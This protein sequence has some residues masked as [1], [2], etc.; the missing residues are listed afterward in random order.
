M[1]FEGPLFLFEQISK[2][3]PISRENL[4]KI[5]RE[6]FPQ[7]QIEITDLAGD[8]DHYS[9]K[10]VDKIFDKKSRVQQHQMVNKALSG[11]LGTTLHALQINTSAN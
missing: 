10:I 11:L 7:A 6:N 2:P 8:N 1:K 9:L 4:E 5:L 3:M